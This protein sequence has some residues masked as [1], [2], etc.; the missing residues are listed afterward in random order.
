M[1][2]V[3]TVYVTWLYLKSVQYNW[4]DWESFNIIR[5]IKTDFRFFQKVIP[6]EL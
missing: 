1:H 2:T 5:F 3:H 6:G 4:A